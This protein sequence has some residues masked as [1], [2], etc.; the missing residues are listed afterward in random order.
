MHKVVAEFM[1]DGKAAASLRDVG[2]VDNC[3]A[4][5]AMD[6]IKRPSNEPSDPPLTSTIGAS[7]TLS[8]E[9]SAASR[10]TG[11]G[12]RSSPTDGG[13]SGSSI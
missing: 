11:T 13:H 1:S 9:Y 10:S 6:R 3:P 2:I 12:N 4:F 8:L 5:A 7:E